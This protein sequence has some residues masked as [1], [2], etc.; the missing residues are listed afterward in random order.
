MD[1]TIAA[2]ADDIDRSKLDKTRR[3]VV[4]MEMIAL[5][6]LVRCGL[7][8]DPFELLLVLLGWVVALTKADSVSH[9]SIFF[10][11]LFSL[12]SS[13]AIGEPERRG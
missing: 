8:V 1:D 11:L 10:R 6:L 12:W 5:D 7:M 3:D 2:A 4:A 13:S 9:G